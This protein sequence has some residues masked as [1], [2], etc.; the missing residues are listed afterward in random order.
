LRLIQAAAMADD[1][2]SDTSTSS[3][4]FQGGPG[5][6]GNR[7]SAP[8]RE[9]GG[10]EP[11]GFRIRLSDNEMRAAR[12]VQEAFRLRSTVAA[13]GFSIRTL[14]QL[15]E[16]GKLDALVAEQRSQ[17]GGRPERGRGERRAERPGG[18][19]I[20]PFA[21]PSRPAPPLPE[22]PADAAAEEQPAADTPLTDAAGEQASDEASEA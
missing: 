8:N 22:T 6:E 13:L 4:G 20:D 9:A 10:R 1:I 11:G 3:G 15:L 14:A 21:R 17:A 12:A 16:E 5:R 19:R 7:R 18:A 2:T